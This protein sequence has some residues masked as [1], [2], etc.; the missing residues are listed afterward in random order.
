MRP[1]KLK[2]AGFGPYA[3][4]Q[5]L[6][7]DQLGT[8]G[9]YLITGD[10][11]AGKTTIFDAITFA[12]FGEASGDY[13]ESDMLRS[14]YAGS[15]DPTYVELTFAYDSKVYTVRRS[16]KYDRARLRGSGTTTQ[17]ADAV[18]TLPDGTPV[19]KIGD[20]DKAVREIIGLTREQFAQV[21]MISQ[22][23]FRK[24]L[25]ADTKDRQ[26]I[27]RDIFGTG[28]FLSLQ[29]KLKKQLA[30]VRDRK[31]QAARSMEQYIG[32]MVCD[33]DSVCA[34]DVKKAKAGQLPMTEVM[35]L[36]ACLLQQDRQAEA[37]LEMQMAET[38]GAA[39]HILAQV[40]EAQLRAAAK[41]S[42]AAQEAAEKSRT[43]ALQAAQQTLNAAQNTVPEQE[44]VSK[45]VTQIDLLLPTYDELEA[46]MS[47][48][49][50]VQGKCTAAETV[51]QTAE[52]RKT[53][54]TEEIAALKTEQTL[55][56]D[57]AAEKEKLTAACRQ[58]EDRKS[59]LMLLISAMQELSAQRQL[60]A[61]L[62]AAYL[63]ADAEARSLQ[64][65]YE[66]KN[67][68]FLREQA[69]II[70]G[71]LAEG[72][73]CPVCGSCSHPQLAV[74][75]ENAPTEADV[76][77]AKKAS[78][79]AQKTAEKASIAAGKQQGI[80]ATT[81]TA[82]CRDAEVLLPGI[83]FADAAGV[84][85]AH[86]EKLLAKIREL[87]SR[88]AEAESRIARKAQL[89]LLIPNRERAFADAEAR[90]SEAKTRIAA[91]SASADELKNQ[92]AVQREKLPFP[93]K[94]AA[95]KEKAALMLKFRNLK[96]ALTHAETT[97]QRAR[98]HLV[99]TQTTVAEL[100]KQLE[101][102]AELDL[103]A[104]QQKKDALLA[105]KSAIASAQKAVHTRIA[106]NESAQKNILK[107]KTELTE[108]ED[109][110]T[111][112]KA[113]SDTANGTLSGKEKIM[114]ETYIQATYFERILERANLRLQ[115]MSGG[116]YDLKR[117]KTASNMREQSGLDLDI[118]DHING[119]ERSVNTLSGGEAF[120]AS[121]ALAL[122]LSDEVQMST[123]IH[124]DTLFVDEGFGSLD[125]EALSKAY[126]TLAG[127]TEGNR[128]VGIISHVSELKERIDR[129]IVVTKLKTGGSCARIRVE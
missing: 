79:T 78:D 39:E 97:V 46:R 28:L 117:R 43:E 113:L 106:T 53:A 84:A 58:L 5:E 37:K 70:A 87:N 123:G 80:V 92:I 85:G 91:L 122:G 29:E 86:V 13:R 66:N 55:L 111:W 61:K 118:V 11:G 129:Q 35:E 15:E 63:A 127:L 105:Q 22:G 102:C 33:P 60:L 119:T 116:Q 88:I 73:P 96:T 93:N 3:G 59:S 49:A 1:L 82:I 36:F 41:E 24:L 98:E 9:L 19:T 62:Q 38:E 77:K 34:P 2:V 110:Y 76:K 51:R 67:R 64:Q 89:D 57:A 74:L 44:A 7:F 107:K 75:S 32:G 103:T 20:V 108:L 8:N 109:T 95:E 14:K 126:A 16:P 83:A 69:G 115:K 104:L 18:L 100:R 27:F 12:L 31:E 54:L 120:L 128:L 68:A 30:E 121:L 26:K 10:T 47:A 114:L 90:L 50:D 17:A 125:S 21:A 112:M 94:A 52:A 23:D 25:Q 99:A 48:L 81:E 40:K 4:V 65:D 42:L 101:G 124:L 45:A 72:M 56:A 71:T 6:D